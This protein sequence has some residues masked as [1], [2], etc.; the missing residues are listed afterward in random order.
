MEWLNYHHLLYFWIVA[1]EGS[2]ARATAVLRLAQPTISA[3]IRSLEGQLGERLF[4]RQGRGLVLTEVG[5]TVYRYADEIFGLGRELLE[6]V[7]GRPAGRPTRFTVGVADVVPKLVAHRL[8]E[9][10]LRLAEP[11]RLACREDH[12]ERLL[13]ALALHEVDLVLTDAPIPPSV[14]VR[15]FSHLLGECGVTIFAVQALAA[16]RR[17]RFPRSLD[18]AP[19]LLPVEATSLR[20][21]LDSWFEARGMRPAVVGEFEDSALLKVFGQAGRGLFAGPTAIE[22]EICAQYA[23]AVVGRIPDVRERF[24]AISP[25]RKI[26]HPAVAAI[27]E[28]ARER[29]FA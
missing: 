9:P 21:A 8:L 5:R 10:A 29:L 16:V 18:G 13:A 2:I 24:Y 20:R 6:V 15:G 11:V 1:R 27:T 3:Q 22:R 14:R 23:V 28:A 7:K 4:A 25:E 12:A 26:R 17:R 19:F